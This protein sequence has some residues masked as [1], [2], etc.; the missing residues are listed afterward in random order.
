[1]KN[2]KSS[3]LIFSFYF[4]LFPPAGNLVYPQ[5]AEILFDS[6]STDEGLN[7]NS[8]LAIHQD[9]DGFM[10]FGTYAGLNRFDGYTFKGYKHKYINAKNI[11]DMHIRSIC[12]DTAWILLIA[13][14]SGVNR[15][16]AQTGEFVNFSHD[17]DDSSSLSMNTVYAILKD[18][19]GDVWLGTWGGGLEDG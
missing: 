9:Q 12:Q 17:P 7:Q 5:S 2:N 6:Y 13:T 8:V 15:F 10:W 18:R 19:D 3:I 16:F 14:T 4:F 11:S 1:M